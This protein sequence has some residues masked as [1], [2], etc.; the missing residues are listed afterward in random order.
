PLTALVAAHL[1][2]KPD[3]RAYAAALE[4][5]HGVFLEEVRPIPLAGRD[6]RLVN[7]FAAPLS[8]S[9]RP[10]TARAVSGIGT[11][12][13]WALCRLVGC[14]LPDCTWQKYS[15]G[16]KEV[17]LTQDGVGEARF[18]SVR[19]GKRLP[20]PREEGFAAAL[21]LEGSASDAGGVHARGDIVFPATDPE[22][23]PV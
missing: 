13:P 23:A 11:A 14:D 21:V 20:L 16:I 10:M 7:I 18:V 19:T 5:V 1:D 12:L 9:N 3:N 2:I 8:E 4:A 17:V 22:D 15:P 6:R